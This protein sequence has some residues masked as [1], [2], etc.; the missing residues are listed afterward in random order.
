MLVLSLVSPPLAGDGAAA[1]AQGDASVPTREGPLVTIKSTKGVIRIVDGGTGGVRLVDAPRG[2]NLS[3]FVVNPEVDGRFLLP[4]TERRIFFNQ[5]WHMYRLP[6]RHV[7]V[8]LHDGADGIA[9]DNPGG[10]ITVAVPHRVGALFVG[11]G[12][13]TVVLDK[14]RGPYVI[15]TD[16]GE[17]HVSDVAGFGLVRTLSGVVDLN[18]AK[19]FVHVETATGDIV[20]RTCSVN[21]AEAFTQA[22]GIDWSFA[23]LGRGA[24][25]FRSGMGE[26]RLALAQDASA[27]VNAQSE[28]GSVTNE[29]PPGFGEVRFSSPHALS[30]ALGGGGPQI[31]AMTKNGAIT[32]SPLI[33]QP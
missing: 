16:E 7:I 25:R 10:D 21:R 15:Q 13:S 8:A 6:P 9:I 31:S 2:A 1:F 22:G 29:F 5:R 20:C 23:H 14:L 17:V 30:L 32:I 12:N 19:G 28:T 27:L 33:S 4:Q 3:H 26:I 18:G 24:Y 11:G